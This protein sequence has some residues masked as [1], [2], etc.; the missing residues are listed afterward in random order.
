VHRLDK[1]T[2]G[3]MIAAKNQKTFEFL[4][5]QFQ[6]RKI[7]K[8]YT[9]LVKASLRKTRRNKTG[10]RQEP[11]KPHEKIRLFQSQ[12]QAPRSHN[13][14][15]SDKKIPELRASRSLPQNRQNSSDK[16]AL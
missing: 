5:A 11:G 14:I 15:Q 2:S 12:R 13:G 3:V 6:N 9:V 16:S 1:D 10:H 7:K 8:T 4:K